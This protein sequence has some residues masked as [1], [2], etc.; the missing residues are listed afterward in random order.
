MHFNGCIQNWNREV[1]KVLRPGTSGEEA[2]P[3]TELEYWRTRMATMNHITEQLK[4]NEC[5]WVL[6]VCTAGK[7]PHVAT[8][9]ELDIKVSKRGRPLARSWHRTTLQ[10]L[11]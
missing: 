4:T 5:K 11:E 9:K 10:P 2:G 7:S 3:D 1:A 8:W 6:G